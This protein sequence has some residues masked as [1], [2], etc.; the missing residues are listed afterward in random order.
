MGKAFI[1]YKGIFREYLH[2]LGVSL[3]AAR[4]QAALNQ[5]FAKQSGPAE[6]VV[7]PIGQEGG[8]AE[9]VVGPKEQDSGPNEQDS[10]PNE[11]VPAPQNKGG[12]E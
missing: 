11:Q 6:Q 5:H 10:G 2:Y 7:G 12:C 9:Q 4:L 1:F 3:G 8:P